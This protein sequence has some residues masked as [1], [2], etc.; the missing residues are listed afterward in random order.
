MSRRAESGPLPDVPG[1]VH[2]IVSLDPPTIQCDGCG[3][4]DIH[5]RLGMAVITSD[6][7]FRPALSMWGDKPQR[8]MCSTCW[9][10]EPQP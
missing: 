3:R 9:E 8:R 4:L 7:R 10:K 6:I 5:E 1:R 2:G